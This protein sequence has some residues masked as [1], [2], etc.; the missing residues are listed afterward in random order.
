MLS[1]TY[2]LL[3][4]GWA[5]AVLDDGVDRLEMVVSYLSDALLD[6]TEATI[7]LLLGVDDVTFVWEDEPG[8]YHWRLQAINT[9]LDLTVVSDPSG[10][11]FHTNCPIQR[12]ARQVLQQLWTIYRD[13]G[14][15]GYRTRWVAHDFPLT[16]YR[17]LE[18]LLRNPPS[19][20]Q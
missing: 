13:F 4:A 18:S 20:E 12:F 6:L 1:F 8:G 7:S 10:H 2:E 11:R 16:Q 9:D 15:D 19:P 14:P 17:R 3:G 5:H